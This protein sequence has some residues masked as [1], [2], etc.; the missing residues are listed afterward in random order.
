M[1]ALIALA[2]AAQV[3]PAAPG[4]D[5]HGVVA[6]DGVDRV[7]HRR[8]DRRH[9]AAQVDPPPSGE[10]I[11]PHGVVAADGEDLGVAGRVEAGAD[12]LDVA[13][14]RDESGGILVHV[15]RA[16]GPDGEDRVL[17]RASGDADTDGG[18]RTAPH[19]GGIAGH[20]SGTR[21]VHPGRTP[22][23]DRAKVDRSVRSSTASSDARSERGRRARSRSRLVEGRRPKSSVKRNMAM[24]PGV[25]SQLTIPAVSLIP[26]R[27]WDRGPAAIPRMGLPSTASCRRSGAGGSILT[28]MR[29]PGRGYL[30]GRWIFSGGRG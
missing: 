28:S 27:W 1:P 17:R 23:T 12:L 7:V 4:V 16:V 19:A 6:A 22:P 26:A 15:D 20:E 24:A 9:V 3:D 21:V 5:P 14:Q 25:V 10:M 18:D 30:R 8:A 29:H 11:D 13:A 2:V